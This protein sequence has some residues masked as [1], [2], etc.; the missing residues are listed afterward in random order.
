MDG[1]FACPECGQIVKAHLQGPG[2]QVRCSF[3][4]RLIEVPFLPRVEGGWKRPRYLPPRWVPWA[5]WGIA[6]VVMALIATGAVQL[7]LRGERAGRAR[8]VD[9][10]IAASRTNESAGRLD[11]ALID[12]DSALDLIPATDGS[13]ADDPDALRT[14]R[15]ALAQRDAR[16]VLQKL[17]TRGG[18]PTNIGDWLNLVARSGTDH[19]LASLRKEVEAKFQAALHQWIDG[20]QAAAQSAATMGRPV[21][22]FAHCTAAAE[23]A[24]HLP[25]ADQR[26]VFEILGGIVSPLVDHY[27]VVIEI[28]ASEF[29]IGDEARYT[30][31]MKPEMVQALEAKGYLPFRQTS[32]WRE[33]WSRAPFRMSLT[34]RERYEGSYMNTQNRLTRIEAQT[35]LTQQGR[36]IWKSIPNARTIVP[37]PSLPTFISSRIALSQDRLAEVEKMLYDNAHSQIAAKFQVALKTLPVCPPQASGPDAP[38]H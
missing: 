27:G 14:R 12:L 26:G 10:L 8:T 1:E 36:E 24:V 35:V 30:N 23:A 38:A 2:R 25:P 37:L 21:V 32:R 7:V 22:A 34:I 17:E 15:R 11:L 6:L 3:C 13:I 31:S 5:W 20:E 9:N 18:S 29:A 19:D 33:A 4:G 16:E 28:A